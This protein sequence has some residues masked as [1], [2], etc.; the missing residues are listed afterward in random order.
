[1]SPAP[2]TFLGIDV[3]GSRIKWSLATDGAIVEDGAL[4]TARAGG[5]ELVAQVVRLVTDVGGGAAGVGLAMPGTVDTR[6][7]ETLVIPNVPGDWW[8]RPVGEQVRRLTGTPLWVLNDARAFGYAELHAGAGIGRQTTLFLTLGTGVGGAL[9]R[10]GRLEVEDHDHT[11]EMGHVPVERHG[12]RCG[13]GATGCLET[14]ASASAIVGHTARAV[15][16]GQ[17]PILLELCGGRVDDL[18][19]EMVSQAADAGDPFARAAFER[20]G[21]M[22]GIAAAGCCLVTGVTTVVIGGGLAGAF[23]HLAPAVEAVLRERE[24]LTGPVDVLPGLLGSSAGSIGAALYAQHRWSAP[25]PAPHPVADPTPSDV[26]A[27]TPPGH[28]ERASHDLDQ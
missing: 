22:I 15:L 27:L 13:C 7:R 14:V 1:M 24:S 3:G 19:A 17:S 21:A 18:T 25:H 4:P 23:H 28:D 26:P 9:A 12:E 11:P 20:A 8:R 6:R 16:T 2:L 10:E 5:D